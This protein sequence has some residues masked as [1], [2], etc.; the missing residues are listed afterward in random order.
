[1]I[2]QNILSLSLFS[3]FGLH[4]AISSFNGRHIDK[5]E[6]N[7]IVE[8]TNCFAEKGVWLPHAHGL[9]NRRKKLHCNTIYARGHCANNIGNSYD[10]YTGTN[11]SRPKTYLSAER[12]CEVM[13][14]RGIS[15]VG[16]SMSGQFA[17]TLMNE[18]H[19][20]M[21]QTCWTCGYMCIGVYEINC[22]KYS[23]DYNMRN[24]PNDASKHV[25]WKNFKV[26]ESRNDLLLLDR[27]KIPPSPDKVFAMDWIH[28]ARIVNTS[29]FLL[30][31]GAHYRSDGEFISQLNSTLQFLRT[32][33]PDAVVIFRNT[34]TGHSDFMAHFRSPPLSVPLNIVEEKGYNPEWNW[35]LFASQ[36]D[37][38]KNFLNEYFP[39]YLYMDVYR[40]TSL[41][42]DTHRDPLHYCIPGPLVGWSELFYQIL[43]MLGRPTQLVD[44]KK[45]DVVGASW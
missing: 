36:N 26:H 14:G 41:R 6:W 21:N 27:S 8:T 39:E 35:T 30:N 34:P 18:I 43:D 19:G 37:M 22:T 13:E 17:S 1:M 4:G 2:F 44:I 10:Y 7:N 42:A 12:L 31:R 15:I 32:A 24:F 33:M 28:Y 20:S 9:T 40:M 11:C 25:N 29:V 45:Y 3:L 23:N 38:V 5:A 16:D